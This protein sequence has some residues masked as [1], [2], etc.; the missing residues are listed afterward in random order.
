MNPAWFGA[1]LYFM[2]W[3]PFDIFLML[4]SILVI[5]YP[6]LAL[7]LGLKIDGGAWNIHFYWTIKETSASATTTFV[8]TAYTRK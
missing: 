6:N 1:A 4:V 3:V 8:T 5:C 2:P 7:I